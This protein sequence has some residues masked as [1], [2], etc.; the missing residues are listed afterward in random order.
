[1]ELFPLSWLFFVP[2]I[3]I[4]SFAVLNLFIG[5]IVDAMQVMHEEEGKP[6]QV[7]A[8]KEDMIMLEQKIDKLSQLLHS[9]SEPNK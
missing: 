1:M 9:K 4:T 7:I 6:K 8:T 2:F 5:I 3:I